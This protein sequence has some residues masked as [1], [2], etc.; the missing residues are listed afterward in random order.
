MTSLINITI[1]I[2]KSG[3]TES[4]P[5]MT[6]SRAIRMSPRLANKR[7]SQAGISSSSTST[8]AMLRSGKKE[9]TVATTATSISGGCSV[10]TGNQRSCV[11]TASG[12][13]APTGR[14]RRSSTPLSVGVARSTRKTVRRGSLKCSH[15]SAEV[16]NHCIQR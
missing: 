8:S 3:I 11:F 9:N 4:A 5:D 2:L 13:R 7:N 1:A 10:T 12:S 16:C 6:S 15:S 14:G